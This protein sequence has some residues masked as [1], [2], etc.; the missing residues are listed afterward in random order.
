MLLLIPLSFLDLISFW[1]I[2]T[3]IFTIFEF[4]FIFLNSSHELNNG[5]HGSEVHFIKNLEFLII[6]TQIVKS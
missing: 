3:G 5:I 1:E 6:F 2:G 4:F